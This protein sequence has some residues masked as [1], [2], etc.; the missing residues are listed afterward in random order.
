MNDATLYWIII[1]LLCAALACSILL[2]LRGN[3]LARRDSWFAPIIFILIL[4]SFQHKN[5]N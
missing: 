1:G 4:V 5:G 3:V 2:M